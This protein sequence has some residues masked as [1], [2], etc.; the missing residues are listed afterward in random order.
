MSP[1]AHIV[2]LVAGLGAISLASA[3]LAGPDWIEVGD[4]GSGI[5]DAQAPARPTGFTFLRSVSGGLASGVGVQDYEDLYVLRITDPVA[6]SITTADA[7]FNA[8]LYLF[9]IT[10][11]GE[12]LGLLGNDDQAAM[13]NLPRL[14]AQ[15]TDGTGVQVSQPGDYVLAVTGFG[16]VPVSRTG[17]MYNL[18]SPTEISGPDGVGGLNPLM[19]WT[20]EGEVGDYRV[21][22]EFVDYPIF[23]APGTGAAIVFGGLLM[24]RRRR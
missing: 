5:F 22:F 10:V 15:S 7:D 21:Q 19:G 13:N 16:R 17:P 20:G 18:M 1:R 23:P 12:G 6:F 9:N 24:A 4:A 3:A 2:R 8:V 11:N 14:V